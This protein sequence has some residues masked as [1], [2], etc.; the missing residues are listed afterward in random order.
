[1]TY[2]I[3]SRTHIIADI[4]YIELTQL[5]LFNIWVPCFYDSIIFI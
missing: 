3:F 4:S 5:L 1:M 2:A